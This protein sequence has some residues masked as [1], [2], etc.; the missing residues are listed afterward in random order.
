MLLISFTYF[1]LA[2]QGDTRESPWYFAHTSGE[3]LKVLAG[4]LLCQGRVPPFWDR[5]ASFEKKYI[6][7][8]NKMCS[9]L[10]LKG[11]VSPQ[12]TETCFYNT[13]LGS[14]G[15]GLLLPLLFSAHEQN[16]LKIQGDSGLLVYSFTASLMHCFL[17]EYL[18]HTINLNLFEVLH[19]YVILFSQELS[20]IWMLDLWQHLI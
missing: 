20:V 11:E 4:Y 13:G 8:H 1:S 19:H 16:W 10:H 14:C 18:S 17:T 7:L 6:Q 15:T 2:R 3:C 5:V 9:E 12:I